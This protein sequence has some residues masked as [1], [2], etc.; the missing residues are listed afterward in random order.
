VHFVEVILVIV[1]L[2]H[3]SCQSPLFGFLFTVN[4]PW[5]SSTILHKQTEGGN[6]NAFTIHELSGRCYVLR[7]VYPEMSS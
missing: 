4:N 7:F 3:V 6:G 5:C 1:T 2:C